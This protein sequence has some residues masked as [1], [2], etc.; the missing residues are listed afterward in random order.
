MRV[1]GRDCRGLVEAL[2]SL[3]AEGAA[4][5]QGAAFDLPVSAPT[6]RRAKREAKRLV[7]T[8]GPGIKAGKV[9]PDDEHQEHTNVVSRLRA[10]LPTRFRSW[11]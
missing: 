5:E 6:K 1:E 8:I 2:G 7:R 11:Q 4:W 10:L 9:S 3:G